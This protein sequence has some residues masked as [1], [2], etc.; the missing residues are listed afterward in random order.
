MDRQEKIKIAITSGIAAV[1]L[2]ILV[3][4]LALSGH[5]NSDSQKLDENIA[6]YNNG[7]EEAGEAATD[8]AEADASDTAS[9]EAAT[10][11][12]TSSNAATLATTQDK[13]TAKTSVSGNSFYGTSGAVLKDV[14]K[15]MKYNVTAQLQ[16]MSA[17]WEAGNTDA[18]R[19]LAHLE[20][21]EAMSYALTG[22]KDFFYSGE[23][24]ADGLPE[25]TGIAVYADSQYY[26]GHWTAGKRD[27]EGAWFSFYPAYSTN[28]VTEHLYVGSWKD[29]LPNGQGQEHYDYNQ[30][31]MND[32]DVYLQ[33]AIGTFSGGLYDGEMYIIT[34]NNSGE[35][36]EWTGKCVKGNWEQVDY[37]KLDDQKRIAVLSQTEDSDRHLYMKQ[38]LAKGNGVRNIISGGSVRK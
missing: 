34:I 30:E 35:T 13:N 8:T 10:T 4:F 17:Y 22:S 6:S 24:N 37:S 12:D 11:E 32:S 19:D 28:V 25:G 16:E 21:F 1:I 2:L 9:T 31:H 18:V 20:R 27:G 36:T 15:G 14:Y 5:K 33:N 38:E 7:T 3:L 29:D 26:Y 23:V